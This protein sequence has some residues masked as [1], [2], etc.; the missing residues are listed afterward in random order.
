MY[1]F[2]SVLMKQVPLPPNINVYV[3]CGFAYQGDRCGK[4]LAWLLAIFTEGKSGKWSGRKECRSVG[5]SIPFLLSPGLTLFLSMWEIC[6]FYDFRVVTH[7]YVQG[8]GRIVT[9]P[10]FSV[11]SLWFLMRQGTGHCE[12]GC[13]LAQR[14]KCRLLDSYKSSSQKGILR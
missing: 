6:H 7:R 14:E 10:H 12:C 8:R 9:K 13:E 2:L 4:R 3:W 1:R 5:E 11:C